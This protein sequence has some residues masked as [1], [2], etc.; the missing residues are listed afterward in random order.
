MEKKQIVTKLENESPGL[1]E[2]LLCRRRF[3]HVAKN[4]SK[5]LKDV[6]MNN[7]YWNLLNHSSNK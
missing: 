6:D 2:E 5:A 4:T 7:N 1:F 3:T